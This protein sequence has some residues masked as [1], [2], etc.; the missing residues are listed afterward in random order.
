MKWMEG[1]LQL[2]ISHG[3]LREMGGIFS[4]AADY[5]EAVK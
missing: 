1:K 4:K 5:Y 3:K 2:K